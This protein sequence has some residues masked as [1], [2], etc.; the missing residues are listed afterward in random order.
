MF[1]IYSAHVVVGLCWGR[2]GT[3]GVLVGLALHV[4]MAHV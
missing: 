4:E 2:G 3:C 1:V